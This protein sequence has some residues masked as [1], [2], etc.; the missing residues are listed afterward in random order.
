MQQVVISGREERAALLAADARDAAALAEFNSEIQDYNARMAADSIPSNG[1]W[2]DSRQPEQPAFINSDQ[3]AAD[4][5]VVARN[6]FSADGWKAVGT[7]L[8]DG[9]RNS[10]GINGPGF[11]VTRGP[12]I[13]A[14]PKQQVA[15]LNTLASVPAF[16]ENELTLASAI[17]PVSAARISTVDLSRSPKQIF[18]TG[19]DSVHGQWIRPR[20]LYREMNSSAVGRES[21]QLIE[22][23]NLNAVLSYA[24][25]PTTVV[26]GVPYVVEGRRYGDTVVTYVRATES[27]KATAQNQIHEITHAAGIGGSQRAE[28][29]AFMR[30]AQHNGPLTI[31]ETRQIINHVKAAYPEY[32]YRLTQ[33]GQG[34][35]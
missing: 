31:S 23:H 2:A 14:T 25:P 6:L 9:L 34:I 7:G 33:P 16:F 19:A 27:L 10:G 5:A 13:T 26:N 17:A 1:G 28:M 12:V 11:D 35:H 32:P 29:I 3:R 15:A 20:N 30:G 21:L 4:A 22:Q 8:L 18:T 24:R